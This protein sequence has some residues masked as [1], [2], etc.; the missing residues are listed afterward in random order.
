MAVLSWIVFGL[1]AL[2]WTA[3]AWVTVEATE[4]IAQALA[5]GTAV[6]AARDIAAL[7]LPQWVRLW[8]DPAWFEA[9]QS[10]LQWAFGSLG[11]SLPFAGTA[12]V[13]ITAAIWIG[14]GFGLLLLL[15]AAAAV[16]VLLRRLVRRRT[17]A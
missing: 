9:L 6:Q 14:W 1:L 11:A 10:A 13:W 15:V 3:G 8:I 16:H 7:P 2:L 5:S 12:A 17:P 4:W